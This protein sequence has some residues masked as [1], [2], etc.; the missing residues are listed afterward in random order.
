MKQTAAQNFNQ[1]Y[2]TL[3]DSMQI[4]WNC[5]KI[6]WLCL[7]L[8]IIIIVI[9][10]DIITEFTSAMRMSES[11]FSVRVMAAGGDLNPTLM[12]EEFK[13]R[14]EFTKHKEIEKSSGHLPVSVCMCG[15]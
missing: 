1:H 8:S 3:Y 14:H 10:L 6:M 9:N 11:S 15:N 7:Q 5:V 13:I 2:Q 4:K 12:Q